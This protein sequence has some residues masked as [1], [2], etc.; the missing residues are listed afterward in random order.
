[1]ATILYHPSS[2]ELVENTVKCVKH[3]TVKSKFIFNY[4]KFWAV[5]P[6]AK[7]DTSSHQNDNSNNVHSWMCS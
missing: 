4:P 7:L 6:V 2:N 3:N 5:L 1:M